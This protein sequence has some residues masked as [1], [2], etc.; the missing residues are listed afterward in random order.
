[1]KHYVSVIK[2]DSRALYEFEDKPAAM[3]RFHQEMK[4][5]IDAK[6]TTLCVVLDANGNTTAKEKF[7][8]PPAPV[9]VESGEGE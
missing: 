1:M 6:S 9:E 3:S 4:Y 8:A 5:A 7:V 2:E